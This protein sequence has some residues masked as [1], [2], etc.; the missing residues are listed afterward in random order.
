M[1]AAKACRTSCSSLP[2]AVGTVLPADATQDV[3]SGWYSTVKPNTAEV[4]GLA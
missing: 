3:S 2:S 4:Y 1:P